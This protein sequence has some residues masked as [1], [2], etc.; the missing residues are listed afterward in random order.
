MTINNNTLKLQFL[1]HLGKLKTEK[2]WGLFN[3]QAL[4]MV[5]VTCEKW[6]LL[7]EVKIL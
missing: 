1:S 6:S 7:Q 3:V 4:K 2:I 5:A